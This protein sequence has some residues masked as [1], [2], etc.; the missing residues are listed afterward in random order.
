MSKLSDTQERMLDGI[1]AEAK[2][3]RLP[4][5]EL[6]AQIRAELER[7]KAVRLRS[8]SRLMNEARLAGI[9][10]TKFGEA[11]GTKDYRTV[12]DIMDLTRVEFENRVLEVE[13]VEPDGSDRYS[14][15]ATTGVLT[16]RY[17]DH[18]EK[19][20][21]GQAEFEVV[22]ADD[23][24]GFLLIALTDMWNE[25]Y[26][27]RNDVVAE[28]DTGSGPYWEEVQTWLRSNFR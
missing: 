15:D 20:I 23:V 25:D 10:T 24:E 4:R 18:G 21:T 14:L 26:T 11:I 12:M 2:I 19:G 17:Q 28:L 16:V 7:L 6:E 9:P 3:A 22:D 1:R 13:D 5:R 8:L 27:V